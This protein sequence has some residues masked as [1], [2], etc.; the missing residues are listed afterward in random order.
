MCP[1]HITVTEEEAHLAEHR[2]K[3]IVMRCQDPLDAS[4][5][6]NVGKPHICR[7]VPPCVARYASE[8]ELAKHY[9]MHSKYFS[10]HI[11]S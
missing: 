7:Q 10:R 11:E 1:E 4:V 9:E 3:S 6:E 2:S 8:D 5:L